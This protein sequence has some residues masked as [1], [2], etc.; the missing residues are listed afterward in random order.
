MKNNSQTNNWNF[1]AST[2]MYAFL[3]QLS[4]K[5]LFGT[6][7]YYIWCKFSSLLKIL[8]PKITPFDG[9]TKHQ[10]QHDI[11]CPMNTF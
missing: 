11:E 4:A 3:D 6:N 9:A 10:K 5:V 7:L 2:S 8:I 1:G